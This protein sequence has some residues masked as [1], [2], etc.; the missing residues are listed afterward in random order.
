M[1]KDQNHCFK[2]Q[3]RRNSFEKCKCKIEKCI[4]ICDEE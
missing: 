1:E 4:Q 3:N 2:K